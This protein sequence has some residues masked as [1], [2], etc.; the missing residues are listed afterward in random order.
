MHGRK[1]VLGG[2]S[3]LGIQISRNLHA[4]HI[5]HESTTRHVEKVTEKVHFLDLS[6]PT[7]S[8][9]FLKFDVVYF[10]AGNTSTLECFK[11][12]DKTFLVNV[13]NTLK[14]IRLFEASGSRI[15]FPSTNHVFSGKQ[16]RTAIDMLYEP[17]SEYGRQKSI[18]ELDLLEQKS[19]HSVVRFGK[20][21]SREYDLFKTWKNSILNSEEVVIHANKHISP[22][23]LEDAASFLIKL[24]DSNHSGLYQ[25]SAPDDISY[26]DV[27][28][29]MAD[30]LNASPYQKVHFY[31]E[32]RFPLYGSME[33]SPMVIEL[34]GNIP[35]SK[36]LLTELFAEI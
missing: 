28:S 32:T 5:D 35:D 22:I 8:F 9:N 25:F 14:L 31:Q 15:I 27:F 16:P 6:N 11:E 1:L 4:L 21:V 10:L 36:T 7:F 30:A 26:L 12:K 18:V 17:Q 34:I 3:K 2:D 29:L 24:A 19:I 33:V 13:T 23:T 20:I